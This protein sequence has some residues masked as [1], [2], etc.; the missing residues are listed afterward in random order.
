MSSS[1]TTLPVRDSR[2]PERERQQF[3]RAVQREASRLESLTIG[4]GSS[5]T[6][7]TPRPPIESLA[8]R[9]DGLDRSVDGLDTRV[10]VLESTVQS[11]A[12]AGDD[13]P[14]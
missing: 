13:T 7:P 6:V 4:N 12:P 1:T 10:A 9:V 5:T 2:V 8:K 3:R 14:G 11:S